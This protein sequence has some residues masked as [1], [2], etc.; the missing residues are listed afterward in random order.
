MRQPGESRKDRINQNGD[1]Q[2]SRAAEA[3]GDEAEDD[4]ANSPGDKKYG[5]NNSAVPVDV[6]SGVPAASKQFS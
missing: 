2:R 5:K 6:A 4:A 1:Y 3:I